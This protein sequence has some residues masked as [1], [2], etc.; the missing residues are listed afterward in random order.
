M[1]QFNFN[2]NQKDVEGLKRAILRNPLKVK[3]EAGKFFV[4]VMAEYNKGI[5]R[6]PWRVGGSGGGSPVDTANMRDTHKRTIRP[7]EAKIEPNLK[8]AP[9]AEPVHKY[10]PWL[11]YV[12][13]DKMQTADKLGNDFLKSVVNDLAK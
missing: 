11:D 13:K 2:F 3:T 12:F 4:R 10:R 8:K 6:N 5:I 7:W 9:Y 1:N